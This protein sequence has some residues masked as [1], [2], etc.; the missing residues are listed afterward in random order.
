TVK[1]IGSNKAELTKDGKTLTLQVQEPAGISLK[2]TSTDPPN[3]Y[4]APNPGTVLVT[5]EATVPANTKTALT[6]LLL[7]QKSAEQ[8]KPVVQPLAQWPR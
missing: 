6:V 2:I 8:T 5:F 7:P 4:D 3:D 1:L